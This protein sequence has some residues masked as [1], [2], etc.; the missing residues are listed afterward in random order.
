METNKKIKC[1]FLCVHNYDGQKDFDTDYVSIEVKKVARKVGPSDT[2]YVLEDTY[3]EH[4]ENIAELINSQAGDSGID[5]YL[6]PFKDLGEPLPNVQVGDEISD[7][8]NMPED[9]EGA[10]DL[11]KNLVKTFADL[12]P[13]LKG[14]AKTPEEFLANFT[15][16]KFNEY[17]Q[18]KV[19]EF[20]SVKESEKKDE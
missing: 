8:T 4:R 11:G 9:L 15:K 13:E 12:D 19:A 6:K 20:N 7:F 3:I 14:G 17:L 18:K 2:D 10:A 5:A 1:G 16:E